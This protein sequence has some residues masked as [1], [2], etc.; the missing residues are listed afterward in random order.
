MLIN[1]SGGPPVARHSGSSDSTTCS[2]ANWDSNYF[3]TKGAVTATDVIMCFHV[4]RNFLIAS[5]SEYL[6][7]KEWRCSFAPYLLLSQ[8]SV[9]DLAWQLR[10]QAGKRMK[11]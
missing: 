2:K 1:F 3:T 8:T 11:S 4:I 7:A 6:V 9:G 5:I 10:L